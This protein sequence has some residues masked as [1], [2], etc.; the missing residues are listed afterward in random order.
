MY[1]VQKEID[2]LFNKWS[3]K[4]IDSKDDLSKDGILDENIYW[5]SIPRIVFLLKDTYG[6]FTEIAPLPEE[7]KDGYG[8]T[9]GSPWFW[10]NLRS[11]QYVIQIVVNSI[12][13]S[14]SNNVPEIQEEDVNKIMETKLT[15]VGYI[16]TKK[17]VGESQ[18]KWEDIYDF[19]QRDAVLLKEELILLEPHIIFCCGYQENP[20]YSVYECLKVIDSSFKDAI[21][22]SNGIYESKGILAIDWWH[23]SWTYPDAKWYNLIHENCFGNPKVMEKIKELDWKKR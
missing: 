3:E 22:L 10:R 8:P 11:W 13:E 19:A 16:N 18:A 14:K 4:Y 9:G 17:L 20:R 7:C 1:S 2:N 5:N 21:K 6:D 12:I 15:G 23:P